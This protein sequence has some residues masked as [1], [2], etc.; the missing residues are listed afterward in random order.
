MNYSS[1]FGRPSAG[2]YTYEKL[3]QNEYYSILRNETRKPTLSPLLRPRARSLLQG[4]CSR[5]PWGWCAYPSTEMGAGM[6]NEDHT[7]P[8]QDRP[9]TVHGLKQSSPESCHP[10][11][12]LLLS[13]ED[14]EPWDSALQGSLPRTS[15]RT[16]QALSSLP[17]HH[18][19]METPEQRSPHER[20]FIPASRVS[21][22][23]VYL[24]SKSWVTSKQG[25]RS[26]WPQPQTS[27]PS[28]TP[29]PLLPPQAP[30]LPGYLLQGQT[31]P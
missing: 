2:K 3:L 11:T 7:A 25:G 12:P 24:Y 17:V 14:G 16:P 13:T 18:K 31:E 30:L 8:P 23:I 6:T 29:P 4:L 28:D 20:S 22:A 27:A 26:R 10:E 19:S 9:L 5:S 21:M 15:P 1:I